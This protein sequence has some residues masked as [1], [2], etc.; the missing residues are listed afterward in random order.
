MYQKFSITTFLIGLLAVSTAQDLPYQPCPLIRAYYPVPSIN[1]SSSA[2][3]SAT[4][5][6]TKLFDNLVKTGCSDA[7]GCISPNTTSFSL[8]LY[9]IADSGD[10]DDFI[11]LDYSHTVPSLAGNNTVGLDTVFPTGTL[12]QVFT[13]YAWLIQMGDGYWEQPIT[14][15][16]PELSHVNSSLNNILVDWDDVSIGSLAG[17]MSGIIRDCKDSTRFIY[18][19]HIIIC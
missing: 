10:E 14:A 7:F 19:T 18:G 11:F 1:K 17:Q 2:I 15:F 9:S 13:V 8:A 12:T 4:A 3:Q 6:F 16:L 5:T